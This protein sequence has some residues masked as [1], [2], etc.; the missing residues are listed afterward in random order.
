MKHDKFKSAVMYKMLKWEKEH[1]NWKQI[2]FTNCVR[3][4]VEFT[5]WLTLMGRL[6]TKYRLLKFGVRN[7]GVC[8]FCKNAETIKPYF[9]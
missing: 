3:P 6:P 8:S 9:L 5:L 7:D 2:L 1:V 4:R